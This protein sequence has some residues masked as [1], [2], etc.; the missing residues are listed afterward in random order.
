M[1]HDK[2][3][4][5]SSQ[6][7]HRRVLAELTSLQRAPV[8]CHREYVHR[9]VT[10]GPRPCARPAGADLECSAARDLFGMHEPIADGVCLSVRRNRRAISLVAVNQCAMSKMTRCRSADSR[11][12]TRNARFSWIPTARVD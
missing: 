1:R 5:R 11:V 10:V 9:T 8:V 7:T 12:Q 3:A 6:A 2:A 4:Y